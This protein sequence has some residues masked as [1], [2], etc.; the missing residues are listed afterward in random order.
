MPQGSEVERRVAG[1]SDHEH[2][3]A[4]CDDS[5]SV[6]ERGLASDTVD[7]GAH[8]TG[9]V[10][11]DDQRTCGA[12]QRPREL[13]R[14]DDLVSAEGFG[15]RALLG[16]LR[17]DD[18][19]CVGTDRPGCRDREQPERTC[20]DE[21]D[22]VRGD[23][24]CRVHGAR[25]RLD[26]H[27]RFVGHLIRHDQQLRRVRHHGH[28]PAAAGGLTEPALQP[29]LEMAERDALAQVD[30]TAR[31]RVAHRREA[32]RRAVQHRYQHGASAVVEVTHDLVAH[33]ERE[34]N[35]GLEVARRR[36][37]DGG[38]VAAADAGQARPQPHPVGIGELRDIDV[39]ELQRAV[40]R[41][42]SGH[43]ASGDCR[44]G[45]LGDLALEAQRLHAIAL[46]SSPGLMRSPLCRRRG[47]CDRPVSSPGLMRSPRV[48]AGAHA[49]APRRGGAMGSRRP[50]APGALWKS[51]I[52]QPRLRAI[53]AR[54]VS[55][56]TATGKPTASSMG[57]SLDESA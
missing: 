40:L 29:R 27:G 21:R 3:A 26:E 53:D 1:H 15:E 12:A 20:T 39:F 57:R 22:V 24:S 47:S 9:E 34:R 13:V 51:S 4:G 45:E 37:I 23:R 44:R 41:A 54:R 10:V 28:R 46:V 14:C 56:L 11:A 52:N 8:A 49:I 36:T 43:H 50:G 17:G 55:G 31:A 33:D 16:V 35:D 48:V 38:E 42:P 2:G 6:G 32:T 25:H 7:D 18:D 19:A 30:G 5:Q